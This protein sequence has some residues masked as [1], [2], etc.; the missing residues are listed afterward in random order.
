MRQIFKSVTV[1][2]AAVLLLGCSASKSKSSPLD[3]GGSARANS[4]VGA[5]L[6]PKAIDLTVAKKLSAVLAELGAIEGSVYFLKSDDFVLHTLDK[7]SSEL[8][9]IDSFDTLKRYV[10]NTTNY[11]IE[12]VKN[13][14]IQDD[15]KVVKLLD[16]D[17]V[18]NSLSKIPFVPTEGMTITSAFSEIEKISGFYVAFSRDAEIVET[19]NTKEST[20]V[21][22]LGRINID[23]KG[24]NV[25]EFLDYAQGVADIYI[26][27]NYKNKVI[28]VSK[29]QTKLFNIET[30]NNIIPLT[31][32]T[33]FIDE[34][35]S[36]IKVDSESKVIINE[37]GIIIVKTTKANMDAAERM[38]TEYNILY[39]D[40]SGTE[41]AKTPSDG[42]I[43]NYEESLKNIIADIEK[44]ISALS[45]V[46]IQG[47][48]KPRVLE[49]F[50]DFK[51]KIQEQIAAIKAQAESK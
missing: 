21:Q 9:K 7:S 15:M 20:F 38:F 8:V 35:K 45:T 16:K 18:K 34:L 28:K 49:E 13:R 44:S 23:F 26:D 22:S 42:E 14:F 43:L 46:D 50:N 2:L 11:T 47:F 29:Y 27:I 37:R 24:A 19:I 17:I 4:A 31:A 33:K 30:P 3:M 39:G 51:N 48:N 12:I 40:G 32:T 6:A 10:E 5:T 36:L 41:V 25:S 1:S